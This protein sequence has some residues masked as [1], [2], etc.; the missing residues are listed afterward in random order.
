[1]NWLVF[2]V[3]TAK[4]FPANCHSPLELFGSTNV[5]AN[6]VSPSG[7]Q[8]ACPISSPSSNG[9]CNATS[10]I[11]SDASYIS[12]PEYTLSLGAKIIA[13]WCDSWPTPGSTSDVSLSQPGISALVVCSIIGSSSAPTSC[14]MIKPFI[15]GWTIQ[16]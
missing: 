8:I 16:K 11:F 9:P 7:V 5:N 4:A 1:M 3:C 10:W 2:L 13:S 6:F 15:Q 12:V 14:T